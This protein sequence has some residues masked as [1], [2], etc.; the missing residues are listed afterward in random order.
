FIYPQ[1]ST[2]Q[3]LLIGTVVHCG[4]GII[5]AIFYAYFFWAL[6]DWRPA[7]QGLVFAMLVTLLAGFIFVPQLD[8]MHPLVLSGHLPRAGIFAYRTGLAGPLNM[9]FGHALYGYIL[10]SMYTH[11]VGYP[12]HYK[13]A[14]G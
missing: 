4:V 12:I 2:W 11:P 3:W 5:W 13:V 9:I 8:L 14:H 10:G 7:I 6:F 1:S